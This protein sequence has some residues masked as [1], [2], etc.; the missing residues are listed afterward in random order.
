MVLSAVGVIGMVWLV[1]TVGVESVVEIGRIVVYSGVFVSSVEAV[2]GFCSFVD[3]SIFAI[4][5][6]GVDS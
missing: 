1:G 5:G 6:G 3:V 2:C 4:L